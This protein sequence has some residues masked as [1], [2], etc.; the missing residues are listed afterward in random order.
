MRSGVHG[1][2]TSLTPKCRIASTTALTTAGVDAMVPASPTPFVPSVL[3]S[4]AVVL[5][6]TSS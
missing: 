1:I 5:C 2:R 6:E 3:V 4:D